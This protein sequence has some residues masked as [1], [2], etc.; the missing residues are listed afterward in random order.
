[1]IG[2]RSWRDRAVLS[3]SFHGRN[4]AS[5]RRPNRGRTT[6]RRVHGWLSDETPGLAMARSGASCNRTGHTRSTRR[7]AEYVPRIRWALTR[8][9]RGRTRS[10]H[11]QTSCRNSRSL[12]RT[13]ATHRGAPSPPTLSPPPTPQPHS[14]AAVML[15]KATRAPPQRAPPRRGSW[16]RASASPTRGGFEPC[17]ATGTGPSPGQQRWR[18][19]VQP[20]APRARVVS[21]ETRPG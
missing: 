3:G 6:P 14:R 11:P 17:P 16:R 8:P 19:G 12:H 15:P 1:M 18:A 7:R 2:R 20:G 5:A 4:C 13:Q 21:T 9:C 10:R